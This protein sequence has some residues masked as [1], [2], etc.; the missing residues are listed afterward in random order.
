MKNSVI[1]FFDFKKIKVALKAYFIELLRITIICCRILTF[2][3]H[4]K[5]HFILIHA[6]K[7]IH[8]YFI[9]MLALCLRKNISK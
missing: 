6:Q 9:Q 5:T 4:S 3:H 7:I 1:F 8:F 2:V